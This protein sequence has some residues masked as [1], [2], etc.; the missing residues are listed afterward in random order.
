[1]NETTTSRRSDFGETFK[2]IEMNNNETRDFDSNDLDW[3]AFC[4]IADELEDTQR[5]EFEARLEVDQV[6]REAVLSAMLSATALDSAIAASHQPSANNQLPEKRRR[7]S[8]WFQP[9]SIFA[10]MGLMLMI[11]IMNFDFADNNDGVASQDDLAEVWASS[12]AMDEVPAEENVTLVD[13]TSLESEAEEDNSWLLAA[14]VDL[15]ELEDAND[16]DMPEELED[17]LPCMQ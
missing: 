6:A 11:A 12:L 16:S 5:S 13:F 9:A 17:V 7:T 10:V 14:L 3:L 8:F 4:Y 1:M 2:V 15:D